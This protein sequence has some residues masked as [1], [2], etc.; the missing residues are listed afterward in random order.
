[1][2]KLRDLANLCGKIQNKTRKKLLLQAVLA[3]KDVIVQNWK[4]LAQLNPAHWYSVLS[5][6]AGIWEASVS[7]K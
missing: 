1:M 4:S 2:K 3:A 6:L 5:E 7:Y